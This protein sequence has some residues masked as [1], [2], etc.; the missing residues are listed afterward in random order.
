MFQELLSKQPFTG[1]PSAYLRDILNLASKLNVG[2]DIVR[3]RFLDALPF[4]IRPVIA[5]QTSLSLEQLGA[6][7][8]DLLPFVNPSSQTAASC[9][10]VVTNPV[11]N[12]HKPTTSISSI[13]FGL[14]P[15][16][17]DQR[18]KVCRSHLYFG[19]QARNCKPWC[20]WPNKQGLQI[21]PS[22]RPSSPAS[23]RAS[24][25]VPTSKNE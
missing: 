19:T 5:A 1:R 15:F 13:P 17:N 12:F 4:S 24:S 2:E 21:Y 8:N 11:N 6:L 22:S 18:P 10:P 16:H 14:K 23:S 20:Q 9:A 3:L 25:P 7:A